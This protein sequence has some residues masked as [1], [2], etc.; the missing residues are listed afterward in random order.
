M[1][2]AL[3][4]VPLHPAGD[5]GA[6]PE[7]LADA[8]LDHAGVV[9]AADPAARAAVGRAAAPRDDRHRALRVRSDHP[10]RRRRA[11]RRLALSHPWHRHRTGNTPTCSPRKSRASGGTAS[12][13]ALASSPA[14]RTSRAPHPST[15][16]TIPTSCSSSGLWTAPWIT[17]ERIA[18]EG[19]AIVCRA[20]DQSLLP[21]WRA[22]A[23]CDRS[24]P[25]EDRDHACKSLPRQHDPAR[26]IPDMARAAGPADKRQV[27]R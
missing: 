17:P 3:F 4:I 2:L 20:D 10:G 8:A 19:A 7:D 14:I 23:W 6:D 5:H 1:L 13:R 26:Q 9:P 25:A 11:R 15:A 24:G 16:R 21:V 27:V 22:D 18:R 12:A